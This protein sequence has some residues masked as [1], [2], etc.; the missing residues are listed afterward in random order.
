V[1]LFRIKI[2]FYKK[3]HYITIYIYN[4]NIRGKKNEYKN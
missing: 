2:E 3:R 4:L 1:L